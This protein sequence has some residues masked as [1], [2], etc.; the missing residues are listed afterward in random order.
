MDFPSLN[1]GDLSDLESIERFQ[2]FS[3][4]LIFST[5]IVGA[6]TLYIYL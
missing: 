1:Y 5:D 3:V 6:G 2:V 4:V